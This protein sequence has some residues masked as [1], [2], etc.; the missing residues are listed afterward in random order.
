MIQD[1]DYVILNAAIFDEDDE[2]TP[3]R[4]QKII[5]KTSE[6]ASGVGSGAG[7][8]VGHT[9]EN[10]PE[11]G[12]VGFL[13]NLRLG[14]NNGKQAI[15]ATFRLFKSFVDSLLGPV[16]E[17]FPDRSV[18]LWEDDVIS[19]VALLGGNRPAKELGKM[20]KKAGKL[21]RYSKNTFSEDSMSDE[22]NTQTE[23]VN[24]LFEIIKQSKEWQYLCKMVE[25]ATTPVAVDSDD[26]GDDIV[27]PESDEDKVTDEE[28]SEEASEDFDADG[29]SGS[30]PSGGNT[31]IP[32]GDDDDKDKDK[33]DDDDKTVEKHSRVRRERDDLKSKY[34]LLEATL[35]EKENEINLLLRKYRS[36]ERERDLVRM[37]HEGYTF[38]LADEVETVADLSDEAYSKHLDKIKK[39]YRRA[40]IGIKF[41]NQMPI[42]VTGKKPSL[43]AESMDKI[44][45]YAVDKKVTW[46]QAL[47]DHGK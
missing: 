14:M 15:F 31:F 10:A 19:A 16:N 37:Q 4:L 6:Y 26:T 24:A 34:S 36:S 32:G 29:D 22:M 3:E 17:V 1:G 25:E 43:S 8:I 33:D 47:K 7:V 30:A 40:P 44:V 38:D 21:Y 9:V 45:K 18:E 2:Y 27:G 12:R 20:Y 23:A 41:D 5:S 13:D 28:T 46:E 39:N 11:L 35:A 42:D